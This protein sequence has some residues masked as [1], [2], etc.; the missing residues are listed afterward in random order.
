MKTFIG[1]TLDLEI[2]KWL[3]G[4]K[5]NKSSYINDLLQ[6]EKDKEIVVVPIDE[7]QQ[8]YEENKKKSE[9][10]YELWFAKRELD[11]KAQNKQKYEDLVLKYRE[12]KDRNDTEAAEK[13]KEEMKKVPV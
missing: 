2:A 10:A 9:A 4:K 13:I 6:K 1:I 11:I 12:A 8:T 5:I 7:Y 3:D